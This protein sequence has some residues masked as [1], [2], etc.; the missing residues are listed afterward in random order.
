MKY[1]STINKINNY[2]RYLGYEQ[3]FSVEFPNNFEWNSV[4]KNHKEQIV[5][6]TC[7]CLIGNIISIYERKI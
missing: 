6:F 4:T 5:Q 3:E 2:I 7:Y 1:K